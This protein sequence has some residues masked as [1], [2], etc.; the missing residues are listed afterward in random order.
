MI[1]GF[2]SKEHTMPQ[3][4]VLSKGLNF[5]SCL[6]IPTPQIVVGGESG[7]C[8][9]SDDKAILDREYN[10]NTTITPEVSKALSKL[11]NDPYIM[12][13]PSDNSRAPGSRT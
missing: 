6:K 8:H 5:T 7:L 4:S 13:L 10:S 12:V 3:K 2:S 1:D 11:K 9:I